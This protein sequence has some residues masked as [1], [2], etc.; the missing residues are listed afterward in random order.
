[1]RIGDLVTNPAVAHP[2]IRGINHGAQRNLHGFAGR[3]VAF[4]HTTKS[5]ANNSYANYGYAHGG[6]RYGD[7]GRY[8][9][10]YSGRYGVYACGGDCCDQADG[11][12]YVYPC[13]NAFWFAPPTSRD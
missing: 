2:P 1:M 5:Y 10:R 9:G 7:R 3:A 12:Y 11:C 4:S 8:G 13:L 6:R